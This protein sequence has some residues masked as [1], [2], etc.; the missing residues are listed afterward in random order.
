MCLVQLNELTKD[1]L[2]VSVLNDW[3][4]LVINRLAQSH[5]LATNVAIGHLRQV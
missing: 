3:S 4:E 1:V 5:L 2:L